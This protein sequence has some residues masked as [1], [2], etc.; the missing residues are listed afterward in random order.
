MRRKRNQRR[1]LVRI[2]PLRLGCHPVHDVLPR[3]LPCL[4]VINILQ[5]PVGAVHR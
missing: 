4:Q 2:D 1:T 3:R 5:K